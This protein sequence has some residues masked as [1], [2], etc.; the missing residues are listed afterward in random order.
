MSK[1]RSKIFP[2]FPKNS[3]EDQLRS[4]LCWA[5]LSK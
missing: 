4:S 5:L 3:I 2:K 1:I